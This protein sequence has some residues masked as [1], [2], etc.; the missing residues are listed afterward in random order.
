MTS[1]WRFGLF[2]PL[3]LIGASA[4]PGHP[5]TPQL[6][7]LL[8][9]LLI[10]APSRPGSHP[11]TPSST[12]LLSALFTEPDLFVESARLVGPVPPSPCLSPRAFIG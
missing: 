10:G 5:Q 11:R 9:A 2:A 12:F 6:A 4:S 8:P 1:D 7:F 3:G